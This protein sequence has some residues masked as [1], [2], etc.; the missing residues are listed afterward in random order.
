M[1]M[2]HIADNFTMQKEGCTM[3]Y[4]YSL[5]IA[6]PIMVQNLI[7]TLVNVADTVMLGYISQSS[8]AAN[9]FLNAV[10]IFGLFG[11]PMLGLKGVALATVIA[12]FA[13][14]AM[15]LIHFLSA[16]SGRLRVRHLLFNAKILTQDLLKISIPPILNDASYSLAG[17]VL[18]AILGRL[19]S[20]VVAANAV[21]VT[22]L[23]LGAVASRGI[24]NATTV[25]L[26]K[27]LGE[28]D[29]AKARVYAKR[30]TILSALFGLAGS[31]LVALFRPLILRVYIGKLT[32]AALNL[33]GSFLLIEA[34]RIFAEAVNTCWNCGCLRS[35][36]DSEYG[37]IVDTITNWASLFH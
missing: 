6:T 25:I 3:L 10:F 16:K 34:A 19:G 29:T 17:V 1:T 35:G 32:P 5:S 22:G 20:D 15:C 31:G 30:M 26:G 9:V 27:A 18:D 23:N 7:S 37:F 13:E 12:R 14:C 11:F 21:A 8:M 36:G 24:S 2:Q 28:G 4:R 33:L